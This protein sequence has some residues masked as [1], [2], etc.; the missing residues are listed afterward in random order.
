MTAQSYFPEDPATSRQALGVE[1]GWNKRRQRVA[2]HIESVALQLFATRGYRSVTVSEIADAAG[3][4]SRTAAR[5]FPSK[6]DYLL[7]VLQRSV[8]RTVAGLER[9]KETDDPVNDVWNLWVDL[10]RTHEQSLPNYVVWARA[11]RTAPE[12]LA[13]SNAAQKRLRGGLTAL[14]GTALGS[15]PTDVRAPVLAAALMAANTAVVSSWV[16]SGGRADLEGL[17]HAARTVLPHYAAVRNA[18]PAAVIASAHR[19]STGAGLS[20][21]HWLYGT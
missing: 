11:A 6:A 7:G 14:C 10:S 12:V 19:R 13:R 8:D 21:A 20:A 18:A 2:A 9:L 17:F 5:Y 16:A 3:V 1:D 15:D 4:S